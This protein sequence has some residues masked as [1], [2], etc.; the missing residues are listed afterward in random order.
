MGQVH[1]WFFF[2]A[3]DD[4]LTPTPDDREFVRWRWLSPQELIATVVDFRRP[5]YEEVLGAS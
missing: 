5:G 4:G 1:R 2:E 3:A